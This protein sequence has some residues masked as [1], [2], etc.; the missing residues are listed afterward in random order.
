MPIYLMNSFVLIPS[1]CAYSHG[2]AVLLVNHMT[3][4]VPQSND[5]KG[6]RWGSWLTPALGTNTLALLP[7]TEI[8]RLV[9]VHVN[10]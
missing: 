6:G 5:N 8:G 4:Q 3:T 2:I 10:E 9:L 1:Q 7:K